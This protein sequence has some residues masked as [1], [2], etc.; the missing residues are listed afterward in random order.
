[1][2]SVCLNHNIRISS[3]LD[4]LF[5]KALQTDQQVTD[6]VSLGVHLAGR[7]NVGLAVHLA[8]VV[9]LPPA[10]V[11]LE[12]P[13]YGRTTLP[14][15]GRQEARFGTKKTVQPFS[16]WS[17]LPKCAGLSPAW[18]T[19]SRPDTSYSGQKPAPGRPVWLP[20]SFNF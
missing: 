4:S 16:A 2:L 17:L 5:L 13:G 7:L 15:Q 20:V 11:S 6:S 14:R 19:Q 3:S 1:M 18:I 10:V 9:L 8:G 12:R